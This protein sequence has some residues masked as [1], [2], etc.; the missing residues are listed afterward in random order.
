[1]QIEVVEEESNVAYLRE[2]VQRLL[3][4]HRNFSSQTGA[5]EQSIADLAAFARITEVF[6]PLRE[7]LI[8][9]M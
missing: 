4:E 6:V 3:E 8:E 5:F 1:M 2:L 9:H 7:A